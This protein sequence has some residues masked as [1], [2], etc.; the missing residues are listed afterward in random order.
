MLL[1]LTDF[2]I[3]WLFW[4]KKLCPPTAIF[5]I[6][7]Y[8]I[9]QNIFNK[10]LK[11]PWNWSLQST[12]KPPWLNQSFLISM[13]W[14]WVARQYEGL[15]IIC[16]GG[17]CESGLHYSDHIHIQCRLSMT[18]PIFQHRKSLM[19]KTHFELS[20]PNV[21]PQVCLKFCQNENG[22]KLACV[23]LI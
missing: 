8:K 16:N 6:T 15:Q 5:L 10:V 13:A 20:E 4:T 11:T 19:R 17:L 7:P 9:L 18:P 2:L 21:R 23:M 1:V 22:T 12:S 3:A 14:A